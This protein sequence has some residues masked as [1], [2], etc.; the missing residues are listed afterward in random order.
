MSSSTKDNQGANISI[1]NNATIGGDLV[2]GDKIVTTTPTAESSFS[3]EEVL[4]LLKQ[5]KV[6]IKES[7]LDEDN[8]DFAAGQVAAA[9]NEAGKGDASHSQ[10]SKEKIGKYLS[11]TKN[12]LDKVKDVGEIGTK[13]WPILVKVAKMLGLSLIV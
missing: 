13:A 12:I 11:D 6:S 9:I 7:S 8:K 4:Q 10:E 5:L 3:Q 2:G 1:G